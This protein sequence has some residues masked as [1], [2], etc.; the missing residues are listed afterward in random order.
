MT[1]KLPTAL[2]VLGF[3][4]ACVP[5]D[6][7]A[8]RDRRKGDKHHKPLKHEESIRTTVPVFSAA[9][10][11][12]ITDY[13]RNRSSN[14]PPGLAKRNG[15]LPP[16]LQRQLERKG[17]LPRGLQKRIDPFPQELNHQLPILSPGYTRGL[18]GG[19]AVIIDRRNR[20]IV[21]VIHNLLN[22]AGQ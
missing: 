4:L 20:A 2:L 17:T 13:Y 14:L 8:D 11:D 18:I 9:D 21:D 19:S 22:N 7:S 16:G 6:A 1:W 5:A 3:A 10:R 12:V 15:N